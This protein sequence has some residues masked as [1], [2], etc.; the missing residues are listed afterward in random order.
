MKKIFA[1]YA[2]DIKNAL[3][4][5]LFQFMLIAPF[6]LIILAKVLIPSLEGVNVNLITDKS[7]E[8]SSLERLKELS[9]VQVVESE[10]QIKKLVEDFDDKIGITKNENGY[11]IIL[12]GNEA[13]GLKNFAYNIIYSLGKDTSYDL[14]VK[15]VSLG[16]KRSQLKEILTAGLILFTV[17]ISGMCMGL[18]VV[19][20]KESQMIKALAV[21]PV[22]MSQYVLSKILNVL[23]YSSVFSAVIYS[24]MLPKRL[25][26][27]RDFLKFPPNLKELI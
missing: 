12:Q 25:L 20:D 1:L 6:I 14:G 8:Q 2:K 9:V 24:L 19:D 17:A 22:S 27:G 13:E 3:R 15:S 7:L 23:I 10:E 18:T 21:S 16:N 4:D 26:S 5:K 11:K